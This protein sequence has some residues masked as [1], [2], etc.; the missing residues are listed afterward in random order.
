M[1]LHEMVEFRI[2]RGESKANRRIKALEFSRLRLFRDLLGRIPRKT[3]LE[4]RG[5]QE[6]C[7]F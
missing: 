2:P 5:V 1:K 7:S 3:V 4:R 6:S